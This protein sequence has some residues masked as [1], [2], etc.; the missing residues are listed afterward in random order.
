LD[1]RWEFAEKYLIEREE[2]GLKRT[3]RP[4]DFFRDHPAKVSLD[5]RVLYNL[6]SNDYLGLR[7]DPRLADSAAAAARSWG[8]GAGASRLMSGDTLLHEEFEAKLAGFHGTRAALA[9]SSGYA[10]GVGLLPALASHGDRLYLDRLCHACLY[11]GARLSGAGIR[12]YRHNDISHLRQLLEKD[13]GAG[14]RPVVVTDT[15]FSM[16]GDRAPI[17]EISAVC[18][19]FGALLV[20]DE[21]HAV[22]VIG[23]GGRGVAATAGLTEEDVLVLATLGKAFGVSGAYVACS[24]LVRDYLVNACRSFVFSTATPPPVVA[25][26]AEAVGIAAGM[27]AERIRLAEMS[28]TFRARL[29]SLGVDTLASTTQ[30]VP[31]VVGEANAAVNLSQRLYDEGVF[32]PAVRPPTVPEGTSRVRFSLTTALSDEDFA[33]ILGIIEKVFGRR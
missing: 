16:D 33:E 31:A 19:E 9:F 4:R 23:P 25:A 1:R 11:D 27:E 6:A 12:R 21:A 10:A 26:A 30:I 17:A 22:G 20:A 24:P 15:V 18:R 13:R 28:G 3:L 32:A 14:G 7:D 2:R 8:C 29:R 5:G